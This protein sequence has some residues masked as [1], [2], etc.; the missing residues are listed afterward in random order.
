MKNNQNRY[1]VS[2]FSVYRRKKKLYDLHLKTFLND[3]FFSSL[4]ADIIEP[5]IISNPESH[6]IHNNE[7]ITHYIT[8]QIKKSYFSNTYNESILMSEP[9]QVDNFNVTN[10]MDHEESIN[11]CVDSQRIT[12]EVLSNH[13]ETNSNDTTFMD[14]QLNSLMY[15][16]IPKS[17]ITAKDHLLAVMSLASKFKFT[18]EASLS[19]LRW[20][21]CASV[22]QILPTNKP[23]LEKVLLQDN[24]IFTKHFYCEICNIYLGKDEVIDEC[25][26]ELCKQEKSV[27]FFLQISL[28]SQIQQLMALPQIASSLKYRFSRSKK[29]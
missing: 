17:T 12:D 22:G 13:C 14:S 24:S 19:I 5:P 27:K 4:P 28:K 25:Y 29:S 21:N 26:S 10:A 3:L 15:P 16:V 2:R 20:I 8:T 11:E 23:A 1:G 9:D 18:Y 7:D 6:L